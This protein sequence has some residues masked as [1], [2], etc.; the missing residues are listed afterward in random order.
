MVIHELI[1]AYDDCRAANLD[2]SN[3]AHHACTEVSSAENLLSFLCCVGIEGFEIFLFELKDLEF[4]KNWLDLEF[5]NI[6][7]LKGE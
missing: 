4:T 1:H 3:C 7:S 5:T 6:L 2:W